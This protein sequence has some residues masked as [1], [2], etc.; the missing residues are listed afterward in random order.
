MEENVNELQQPEA[1]VASVETPAQQP[2]GVYNAEGNTGDTVRQNVEL[3]SVDGLT[4]ETLLESLKDFK[5]KQTIDIVARYAKIVQSRFNELSAQLVEEKKQAFVTDGSDEK[6][7]VYVADSTETDMNALQQE[8]AKENKEFLKAQEKKR[9]HNLIVKKNILEQFG[10]LV[11]SG[12]AVRKFNECRDW[13]KQ[14][15]ETGP[16]PQA[17]TREIN[18]E[19]KRLLD[20]YYE[21][22]KMDR[23][24]REFGQK[25]NLEEK[26]ALCEAVEAL[27][28]EPNNTRAFHA[29]QDIFKQ[30]KE[31]G[32]VSKEESDAV[33]QRF[34][35]ARRAITDRYHAHIDNLKT[36][37]QDN[38]V[39]KQALCQE[40]EEVLNGEFD[41]NRACD[42]ALNKLRDVQ[43]RWRKVGFAPKAVSEEIFAKYRQLCD[44]IYRKRR[45]FFKSQ[46]TV[47][48]DNLQQKIALCEKAETLQ[49]STD[50]KSTSDTLKNLQRQWKTIG[51]VSRKHSDEVWKRFRAACD[52]FFETKE[53]HFNSKGE[54][55]VVNLEKKK[56][57]I[58]ELKGAECSDNN[59]EHLNLIKSFQQ[60]W[61]EI[62]FVPSKD[63]EAVNKEFN[64][65]IDKH[66]DKLHLDSEAREIKSFEIKVE[67]MAQEQ[68]AEDVLY[69]ERERISRELKKAETDLY[70]VQNN[71]GFFANMD[72]D[73]KLKR[74]IQKNIDKAQKVV[75]RL[76]AHIKLIDSKLRAL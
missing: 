39:Q 61:S 50:W 2:I 75:E 32:S 47:L 62:G 31:V 27:A 73:N 37:E 53:K 57:L 24:M 16:V 64:K 14:W 3:P 10:A 36:T 46:D 12:I 74:D 51:P 65:L 21:Q 38:Y 15:K 43:E 56:A 29:M 52:T 42:I 72:D 1:P 13:Q 9:E 48:D 54:E 70:Q 66:F 49:N 69:R 71:A 8:I 19:Y 40:L 23:E 33:W 63:K 68:N 55:Y 4:R 45:E 34:S 5:E 22:V 60:R 28:D 18:E 41:T 58:E 59:E 7:F 26:I 35:A 76:K 11:D 17:N 30:W 20:K 6:D 67:Q 25:K 44:A